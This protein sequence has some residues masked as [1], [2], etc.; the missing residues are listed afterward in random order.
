M[1]KLFFLSIAIALFAFV[2]CSK[3]NAVPEISSWT[4]NSGLPYTSDSAEYDSSTYMLGVLTAPDGTGD[5]LVIY[6][7]SHPE[8]NETFTV[9]EN[10]VGNIYPANNCTIYFY[11]YNRVPYISLGKPGDVVNL[12]ISGGKL[13]AIFSDIVMANYTDTAIFSGTIIEAKYN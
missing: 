4:L 10:G 8:A 1:P 13:H 11:K 7:N 3:K 9:T 6:F 12:T 5:S 2:S